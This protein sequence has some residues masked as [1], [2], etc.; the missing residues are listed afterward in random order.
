MNSK[1]EPFSLFTEYDIFLF[2]AGTHFKLYEKMGSH[3]VEK[4]GIVGVYF[5]VWAPNA[6]KVSVI[7]DFNKWDS[8][9]HPLLYRWDDSGI[10]E[11]FIEGLGFD[12]IYKY[13]IQTYSGAYLEKGDPYAL[14]WQQTTQAASVIATTFYE[15][16]DQDWMQNRYQKN[17]LESPMSVYE[18]H[19]ASWMRGTD[20]PDKPYGF[21]LC[22]TGE[23]FRLNE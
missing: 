17:S 15:W 9:A 22:V 11:G 12:D 19:L 14:K 6:K 2:K 8:S 3:K 13:G 23:A 21:L 20:N 4:D 7:G 16:K 1:V 5:A 10:W 18:V